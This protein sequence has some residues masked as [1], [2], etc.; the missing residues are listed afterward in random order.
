MVEKNNRTMRLNLRLTE[1]ES[2]RLKELAEDHELTMSK[3]VRQQIFI[4]MHDEWMKRMQADIRSMK[5]EIVL[6]NRRYQEMNSDFARDD[7]KEVL[8]DAGEKIRKLMEVM[9]K[10]GSNSVEEH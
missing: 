6:A 1:D 9:E 3:F 7:L 8:S 2:K 10:Y 4:D 5:N